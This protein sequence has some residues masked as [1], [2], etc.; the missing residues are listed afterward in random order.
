MFELA[1]ILLKKLR[2]LSALTL[3]FAILAPTL[4]GILPSPALSAEQQLMLDL[5]QNI[6]SQNQSGGEQRRSHEDHLKC[7]ILC[8]AEHHVFLNN[9]SPSPVTSALVISTSLVNQ[10]YAVAFPR[11]PPDLR[12]S[13][14]RGPPNSL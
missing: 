1:A 11:A 3:I 2:N 8:V 5:G 13:A 10:R 14:P 4:I 12:S 7:C 9:S 6:C